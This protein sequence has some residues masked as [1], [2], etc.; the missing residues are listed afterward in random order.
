[1]SLNIYEYGNKQ[2]NNVINNLNNTKDI[3]KCYITNKSWKDCHLGIPLIKKNNN[4]YV[5]F[6]YWSLE[7]FNNK[8]KLEKN[9]QYCWI[10]LV[11]NDINWKYNIIWFLSSILYCINL[12]SN[13]NI[14]SINTSDIIEII[15]NIMN[16]LINKFYQD[17]TL[18]SNPN[19]TYNNN[20]PELNIILRYI[21]DINYLI[22]KITKIYPKIKKLSD[23]ILIDW[24]N[25][26]NYYI[27]NCFDVIMLLFTSKKMEW[28]IIKKKIITLYLQNILNYIHNNDNDNKLYY[29]LNSNN[30]KKIL[31]D[32]LLK[33]PKHISLTK[34]IYYYIFIN[35]LKINNIFTYNNNNSLEYINNNLY[36][37]IKN[38]NNIKNIN[39]IFKF[40]E[41]NINLL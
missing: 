2:K 12:N 28:N 31:L 39:D 19:M 34:I 8:I 9:I 18:L 15:L 21:H 1:M 30:N 4:F 36:I 14:N 37:K 40:L 3:Y 27:N 32:N 26:S 25:N 5:I 23:C 22:L 13:L 16:N 38:I 24:L 7:A 20:I 41:I 17:A 35:E 33:L 29:N 11:I 10:P 6:Q